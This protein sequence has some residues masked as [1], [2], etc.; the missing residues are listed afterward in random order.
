MSER[1]NFRRILNEIRQLDRDTELCKKYFKINNKS[2]NMTNLR[3]TVYGPEDSNYNGYGFD[4]D[5]NLPVD[6]PVSPLK[7]KF[8]TSIEHINVSRSGEICMDILKQSWSSALNIRAVL[9]SL[10]SLLSNPNPDDPLNHDLAKLY[11]KN[12]ED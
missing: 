3:A 8:I 12:I 11:R 9:I 1:T 4:V 2:D 7:I 5:I 6:Y 10:V